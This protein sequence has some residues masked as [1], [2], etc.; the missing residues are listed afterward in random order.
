METCRYVERVQNSLDGE[1][2]DTDK[3]PDQTI[4]ARSD[5]KGLKSPLFQKKI[6]VMDF[7]FFYI[8]PNDLT[9]TTIA[10]TISIN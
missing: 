6:E 3:Y 5:L 10:A 8:T 9:N 1:K 2:I 7:K 4:I